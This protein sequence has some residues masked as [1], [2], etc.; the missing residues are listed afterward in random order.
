MIEILI[1]LGGFI[2]GAFATVHFL[3]NA[4]ELKRK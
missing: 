1:F 2:S 3:V 4:S